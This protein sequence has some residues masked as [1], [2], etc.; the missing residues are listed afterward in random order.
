M[1]NIVELAIASVQRSETSFCKF[2]SANDAG[3]TGA[4]Q[5][6][7]YIPKNSATLLFDSPG[8]KGSNKDRYVSIR[9]QND[10]ETTSRFI[11]YGAGTRNEYRITRFGRKFPYL[12]QEALGSLLIL[13]KIKDDYYEG[14]VLNNDD[15]FETF[16]A[17][18][19]IDASETN[20]LIPKTNEVSVEQKLY[21]CYMA[22]VG[23]LKQ[24]FPGTNQMAENARKCYN[25]AYNISPDH[26]RKNPDTSILRWLEAEF[27]LFKVFENT[28]YADQIKQPFGSVEEFVSL[29]NTILNRRK[30]RAGKSLEYHLEEIF[31][32]A[33]LS[34][35]A[36]AITEGSKKPDFIFPHID[37]YHNIQFN[38]D[39]LIF[40]ASK[41]TCK[42]RWRQILNEADRIRTK[43]LFTLQQGISQNQLNEMYEHG[44]RLVVPAQ[45]LDTFPK[46]YRDKILSLDFFVKYARSKS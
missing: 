8:I 13:S 25:A 3:A 45:Y 10:F 14:Y 31:R 30:S 40:L 44:V 5:S 27:D 21:L 6:G 16:F 39:K 43:H 32:C 7:Y 19:N 35:S 46:S 34:F 11:Y 15:D 1:D 41:T 42:D 18:F 24:Q 29:A 20:K 28:A 36:Q 38:T 4:H 12:D 9:W 17:A 33:G 2:I 37:A 23:S 26:I 22:F